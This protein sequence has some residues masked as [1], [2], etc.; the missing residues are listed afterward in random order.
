MIHQMPDPDPGRCQCMRQGTDAY[1]YPTTRRCL[2]YEGVPHICFFP[3]NPERIHS[4]S[5]TMAGWT[6]K[7]PVP[8]V[9]PQQESE[10][11]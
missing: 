4:S 3:P 9:K 5:Q 11:A 10:T 2:D 6:H 7:G 1:G 8:W